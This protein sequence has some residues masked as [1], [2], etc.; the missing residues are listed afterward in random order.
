MY[1]EGMAKVLLENG[2]NKE[3]IIAELGCYRGE[4][5]EYWIKNLPFQKM[6]CIDMW[7]SGWDDVND[8]ASRTDLNEVERIFDYMITKYQDRNII[9]IKGD[10]AETVN[11]LPDG[12]FDFIYI[13]ANHLYEFVK[14]DIITC[15]PKVKK[16]FFLCGHDYGM[17]VHPDVK[18]AVDEV[19][20]KPDHVFE[21]TI[22]YKRIC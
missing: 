8:A 6:Y 11:S 16:G 14:R 4:S 3:S 5:T 1:R 22:W 17:P 9:K 21:D 7:Q 15:L 12:Y 20:G 13:D 18:R 2:I 19:I 10:S